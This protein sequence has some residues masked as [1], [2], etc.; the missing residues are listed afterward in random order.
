M[1]VSY[2]MTL[3]VDER[4]LKNDARPFLMTLFE[5]GAEL[6]PKEGKENIIKELVTNLNKMEERCKNKP[7]QISVAELIP[8]AKA[9]GE[10]P[11]R[12]Y[13]S[14]VLSDI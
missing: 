14:K 3:P 5:T 12:I 9:E 6:Y 10:S 7:G 4:A 1:S 8:A 11:N 13:V 2:S